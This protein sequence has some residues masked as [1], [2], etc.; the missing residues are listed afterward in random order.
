MLLLD[1]NMNRKVA[2][3]CQVFARTADIPDTYECRME[4]LVQDIRF[5]VRILLKD[6][7][8]TLTT[9]LTLALCIGANAAIFA[10]VNSVLL[11]PLPV[12]GADRLVLLYNSYPGAGVVRASSGAPDYY[13]RLRETDVF[14]DLAMFQRRGVTVGGEGSAERITALAAR[15]SLF[16]MLR[17]EPVRG[18]AFSEEEAEPGSDRKVVLSYAFWQR[19]FAGSDT[20]VGRDVRLN[21]QPYQVVGVLPA[22]FQFIE[23]DIDLWLP[24]AFTAEQRSDDARHSNN[25]T[26]VGRLKPGASVQ[27]ARQQ[28]DALNA[29]NLERFANMKELLINAGFHTI[30]T[31][32]HDDLVREVRRS[33][34]LLWGGVLF[35]LAIGAVNITNLVLIRSTARSRELATRHALGAGL[36]R[37]TRQLL[38]ETL[39]LTLVGAA[40]GVAVG[41]MILGVMSGVG[42]ESLPRSSEI[43]IDATVIGFTVA[44]A[45]AVGVLVGLVPVLN[46]RQVNLSQAF[47]EES[48]SGTTGRGTR[49]I[50]RMLVASQ[51]AFAFMLLA[52]AGLLLASF[53]R[54]LGVAPGFEPER[55][56]TARV[57]PPA[58][59][60]AEAP[61]LEAFANRFLSAV[62]ALPGITSAGLTSNIPFGE[63]FSDSVILAEGYQMAPGESLV[64]PYRVV[65]TPGYMEA[66]QIPLTGGRFFTDSDTSSS[67]PVAIVDEALAA[68]FWPGQDPVGRRLRQPQS[69]EDF[70]TPAPD[71]RWITVV[72]VVGSTKMAGL[73]T[74]DT[75]VGTYYFPMS[76]D[77]MRSMTLA[78]RT[79]GDPTAITSSLRQ[80]LTAID[81][82]LPLYA[83][84]TM[85][86]RIDESLVDRRTPMLLA[87]MFATAALLLAAMG[88]YGVLAY[89]V[90]Q[91][92]REIGIRL[93]LGSEPGGIF[94]LV[95]RE[96]LALLLVGLTVGVA[97]AFAIRRAMESQ[98]YGVSAMDPLVLSVVAAVLATAAVVACA[99]PARRAS[100]IDP[101]VALGE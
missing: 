5:S 40:A 1:G 49:T 45:L 29:R 22:G 69:P 71:T 2:A 82:E 68:K 75:R 84:R 74:S 31:P 34:L 63:D 37:L 53:E 16:R 55:V 35:V 25:W 24:L 96:G 36:S 13:D 18:R 8:F 98:L 89:Q 87:T 33:L 73:V 90:A 92:R 54:V 52:G 79:T 64:S 14:E 86:E 101:I 28:I 44:L 3:R 57:T 27:Q 56:L 93:A 66:L 38:T 10:V 19:T 88:L 95:L 9:L 48:R 4:R 94:A 81:P 30:V 12:P 80:A 76:Q 7:A 72:G 46:L 99:V 32:L 41:Y 65:A 97:G 50:R 11:Q 91:R 85:Q 77:G 17:V 43:R 15:P 60:Y 26:M 42:V 39:L 59:R 47:R 23:P 100:R 6:R 67:Q 83:V 61:Q 62:R 20:A 70:V 51:V 58:S 21:G 78:V